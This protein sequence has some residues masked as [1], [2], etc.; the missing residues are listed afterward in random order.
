MET[1]QMTINGWKDKEKLVYH[2][3]ECYSAMRR[4]DILS[5]V[6][7]WMDHEHIMLSDLNPTGKTS[8]VWYPLYVESK[9]VKPIKCTESKLLINRGCRVDK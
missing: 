8:T 3:M 5:F 2:T 1:T 9:K 7:S 4:K 6:T